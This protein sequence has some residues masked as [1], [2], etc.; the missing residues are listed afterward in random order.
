M[1]GMAASRERNFSRMAQLQ[2]GDSLKGS[3]PNA[4]KAANGFEVR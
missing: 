2:W 4:L 1:N 3:W